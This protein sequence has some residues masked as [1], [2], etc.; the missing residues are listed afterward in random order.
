MYKALFFD[1][2]RTLW[3]YRANSEQTIS[4]LL[5]KFAPELN[6]R[7]E[8]FLEVFYKVNDNLWV[9]YRDGKLKKDI[10]SKK[11]FL[12]TFEKFAVNVETF[13]D[14]IASYYVTESPKKTK[15]FPNTI[16]S[17]EYLK[18]R[19]YR[20]CLLTNGFVEVQ[21]VKIRDSKLELFFEKMFTSEEV[22]YQKPDKR[23][24]EFAVNDIGIDKSACIM[25]GDD[26]HNDIF[27][28]QR[29]GMDTVFF[30]PN[31]VKHNSNSTF[32]IKDL[33]EMKQFL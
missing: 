18:D 31:N 26:L 5:N 10:L 7:F 29:F 9:E 11:R 3:D 4:D 17:L 1:L 33:S 16:S 32:E 12:D 30:N 6:S 8:E 14:E 24:F 23:I 19:G 2:D 27:G 21:R 15:L 25:I 22:G 20:L 13:V 28:A